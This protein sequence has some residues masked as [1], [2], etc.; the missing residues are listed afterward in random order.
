MARQA[1]LLI[2]LILAGYGA[3]VGTEFEQNLYRDD[4]GLIRL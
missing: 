1:L 3:P 4:S 2:V